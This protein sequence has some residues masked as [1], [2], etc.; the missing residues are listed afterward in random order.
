[1]DKIAGIRVSDEFVSRVQAR[2]R[3]VSRP[4]ESN[5]RYTPPDLKIRFHTAEMDIDMTQVWEDLGVL[6]PSTFLRE[7]K[8]RAEKTYAQG[9]ID[10]VHNGRRIRD[11]HKEPGNVYGRIAFE[12]YMRTSNREVVLAALPRQ[13]AKIDIRIHPPEIDFNMRTIV[14]GVPQGK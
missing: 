9:I 4:S 14:I 3:Q 10:K 12:T 5:V 11:I 2:V 7:I 8:D 13:P 1:M 6:S